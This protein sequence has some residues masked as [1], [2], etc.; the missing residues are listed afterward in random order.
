MFELAEALRRG[1]GP[2]AFGALLSVLV[3]ETE[4]GVEK[5]SP[6][7]LLDWLCTV[8]ESR[9]P[10]TPALAPM[11]LGD[12]GGVKEGA[13]RPPAETPPPLGRGLVGWREGARR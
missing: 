8:P 12:G 13:F 4:E 11:G 10:P 1:A 7:G 3:G 9:P 5:G 2:G 6:P